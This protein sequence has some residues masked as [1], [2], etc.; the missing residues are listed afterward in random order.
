M[1][2][3]LHR[4]PLG[5][6]IPPSCRCKADLALCLAYEQGDYALAESF[7]NGASTRIQVEYLFATDQLEACAELITPPLIEL[8]FAV[9]LNLPNF[10]QSAN[11][12]KV[13]ELTNFV[14]G[15]ENR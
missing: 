1:E 7:L 4:T 12:L 2:D 11:P 13:L 6:E 8:R 5:F 9:S 14:R 15:V 3:L 10:S